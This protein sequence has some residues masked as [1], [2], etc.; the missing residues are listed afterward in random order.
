[1]AQTWYRQE[2]LQMQ[3][4]TQAVCAEL[5]IGSVTV[6][7]VAQGSLFKATLGIQHQLLE[8]LSSDWVFSGHTASFSLYACLQQRQTSV[9]LQLHLA[10][11]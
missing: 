1:M 6:L 11:A 4:N 9:W 8:H 3:V 2:D 7:F 10:A 5:Q